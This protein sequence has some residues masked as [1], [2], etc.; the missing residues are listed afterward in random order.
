[1]RNA[2]VSF[3]LVVALLLGA[4]LASA[5]EPDLGEA[6]N[7]VVRALEKIARAEERFKDKKAKVKDEEAVYGSL[8]DLVA[9]KVIDASLAS[10]EGFTIAVTVCDEFPQFLFFAAATPKTPGKDARFFA[11]NNAGVVYA[12]RK[13]FKVDAKVSESFSLPPEK[14]TA[15][16]VVGR[17]T[18]AEKAELEAKL[19]KTPAASLNELAVLEAIAALATAEQVH[20]MD[21]NAYAT[22]E[23]LAEKKVIAGDLATG[24]AY[25]YAFKVV[26]VGARFA[27]HATPEKPAADAHHFL[28]SA[29]G[30]VFWSDKAI[31]PD[32]SGEP[33][34]GLDTTKDMVAKA[35]KKLHDEATADHPSEYLALR[36]LRALQSAEETHFEM[37]LGAEE[38]STYGTLKELA[39]KGLID[40]EL[41]QG[42]RHGYVFA[43]TPSSKSAGAGYAL[44]A[45]PEKA[46]TGALTFFTNHKGELHSSKEP[47][48]ADPATCEVPKGMQPV[49]R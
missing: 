36:A 42:K 28:R 22:I 1:M 49:A 25:G 21:H 9:A 33:P 18:P 6:E 39:A 7:N 2:R 12:A 27:I 4:S 14:A 29:R 34:E 45:T 3:P 13:P 11:I 5:G 47:V 16:P 32:A 44:T 41:A 10:A 35:M 43:A 31:E 15:S 19:A 48:T 17:L 37:H 38:A 8:D 30:E 26:L 40:E 20:E 46:G 23:Q 24:K